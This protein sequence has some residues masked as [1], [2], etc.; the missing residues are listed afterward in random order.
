MR[1]HSAAPARLGVPSGAQSRAQ[2]GGA[3]SMSDLGTLGW[4][5]KAQY[6]S[7]EV[8]Q[9]RERLATEGGIPNIEI[10]DPATP[11]FAKRAAELLRRDGYVCVKDV[12]DSERL[13]R[14]RAGMRA[15]A[16]GVCM[17]PI[18]VALMS[19]ALRARTRRAG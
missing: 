13:A 4:Q 1:A 9:L 7:P 8:V 19:D 11:N 3:N 12:L 10:V 15:R 16:G 18:V 17:S 6:D 2:A 14:I 5:G